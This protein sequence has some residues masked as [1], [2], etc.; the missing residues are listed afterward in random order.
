MAHEGRWW[1]GMRKVPANLLVITPRQGT[2]LCSAEGAEVTRYAQGRAGRVLTCWMNS[3]RMMV[4]MW[5]LR[6]LALP[7]WNHCSCM[8]SG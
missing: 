2:A 8:N 7:G 4:L 3:S 5:A 1:G 6:A